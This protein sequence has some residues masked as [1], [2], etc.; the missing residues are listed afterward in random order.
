MPALPSKFREAAL[1]LPDKIDAVLAA[2]DMPEDAQK[3]EVAVEAALKLARRLKMDTPVL[4]A[5]Q[6]GRLKVVVRIGELMPAQTPEQRGA[7]GGRG[8][9]ATTGIVAPFRGDTLATYRKVAANRDKLKEYYDARN[10]EAED[11]DDPGLSDVGMSIADF[12]RYV[13]SDGNIKSNQNQGVVEWYTPA[14][15]IEAARKVMGTIDLDP[16]S[17]AFAQ[18]VVKA[19]TF[20]TAKQ[21]GLKQAWAG[22]VFLN[23]PFKMPEVEQFILKLCEHCVAGDVSQAVLVTN[24]NTDTKWWHTA[25]EASESICFTRGRIKWY[26]AAQP[27]CSPTNGQTFFYFG[28]RRKRF[29]DVFGDFGTVL[30]RPE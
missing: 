26:N 4:N 19:E 1:A 17:C 14:D 3:A 5:L 11:T 30:V 21:D 9:K 29:S 15:H 2:I 22:T 12:V 16:A 10:A 24:N 18:R 13:G 27:D 7:K 20:Y 28:N 23:P 6:Y 25:A 8:H